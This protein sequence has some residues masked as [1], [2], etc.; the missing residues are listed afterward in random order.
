MTG[1]KVGI[2]QVLDF[3]N[4]LDNFKNINYSYINPCT[5]RAAKTDLTILIIFSFWGKYF[6]KKC[7]SEAKQQLHYKYFV[8][9]CFIP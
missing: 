1:K 9:F 6:K 5:L 4:D 7:L 8:N 3:G 2:I